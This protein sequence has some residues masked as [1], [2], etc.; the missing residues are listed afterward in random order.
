MCVCVWGGA[1]F[2]FTGHVSYIE[3]RDTVH[4]KKLF[5]S[6]RDIREK[7]IPAI[8]DLKQQRNA[9]TEGSNGEKKAQ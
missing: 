3:S 7:K 5:L 9:Q 4:I 6:V 8:L 1:F 2:T